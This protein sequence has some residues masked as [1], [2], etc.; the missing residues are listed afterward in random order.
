MDNPYIPMLDWLQEE[1]ID[2]EAMIEAI[3]SLQNLYDNFDKLSQRIINL[4]TEI[5]NLK[6]GKK[7]IKSIFSFKSKNDELVGLENDK[8]NSEKNLA[9]LDGVVKLATYNMESYIEYF[10]VEKLAGY[11]NNLKIFADLQKT[12]SSKINEMWKCV[13]Q[14]KNVQ[15][16]VSKNNN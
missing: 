4:D 14:D 5:N 10:K 15:K 1:E 12:N 8:G 7:S 16:L 2:I 9:D 6:T 13:S 11:Y 3:A